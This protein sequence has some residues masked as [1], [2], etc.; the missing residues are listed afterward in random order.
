ML[1]NLARRILE[2]QGYRVLVAAGGEEALAVSEHFTDRIHLLLTDVIMPG[3][4]GG[5]VYELLRGTRPSLKVLFM[6]GYTGDAIAQH[7]VL[8]A[9]TPFIQKPFNIQHLTVRVREVLDS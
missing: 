5:E 3:T 8:D 9:R 2:R 7:G 4:N 6:S 1:R